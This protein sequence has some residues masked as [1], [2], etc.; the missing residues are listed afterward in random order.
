M[1]SRVPVE[2]VARAEQ[3]YGVGSGMSRVFFLVYSF[4]YRMTGY[5]KDSGTSKDQA[6]LPL[7]QTTLDTQKRQAPTVLES[8][9]ADSDVPAPK[10]TKRARK[11]PKSKA[12][13]V[14][15]KLFFDSDEEDH[16]PDVEQE[17]RERPR[18]GKVDPA[19]KLPIRGSKRRHIIVDDDSDDGVAFKGFGKKRRI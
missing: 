6:S 14:A 2:L 4:P 9:G 12:T 13:A 3:D 19:P 16:R 15:G 1:S 8:D 17:T 11:A 10:P 18:Q 5:W 7:T